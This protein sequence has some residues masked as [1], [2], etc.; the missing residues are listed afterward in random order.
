MARD[1]T[2]ALEE[3]YERHATALLRLAVLACGDRTVAED[4]VHDAFVRWHGA[5]PGPEPGKEHAY[6]RRIVLNLSSNHHRTERRHEVDRLPPPGH[7][8]AADAEV[9]T[10]TVTV[11]VGEAVRALPPRQRDC[12]L[13]HYFERLSDAE[14]ADELHI[15]PG[16]VKTHLHRARAALRPT[17]EQLR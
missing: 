6:L 16:S 4:V 3:L 12:V 10:S 15:S 7:A 2:Q 8:E 5:D 13:L 14:T 9:V 1:P 11:V 17:L